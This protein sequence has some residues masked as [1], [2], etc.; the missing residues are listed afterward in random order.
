VRRALA[1]VRQK[2]PEDVLAHFRKMLGGRVASDAPRE[3]QVVPPL[4]PISDEPY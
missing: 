2:R 4:N 1:A 3:R